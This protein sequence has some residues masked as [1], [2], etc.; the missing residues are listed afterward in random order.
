MS[1]ACFPDEL[2]C[3]R[4]SYNSNS[5]PLC[6]YYAGDTCLTGTREKTPVEGAPSDGSGG[7]SDPAK[8]LVS[9]QGGQSPFWG[10][11]LDAR[12][13]VKF[14]LS[15]TG[16][17]EHDN[18]TIIHDPIYYRKRQAAITRSVGQGLISRWAAQS[19]SAFVRVR[20]CPLLRCWPVFL[21]PSALSCPD[22]SSI[23]RP[24]SFTLGPTAA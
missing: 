19:L 7:T 10:E 22:H 5:P 13:A 21:T 24:S 15:E 1:V 18:G 14:L 17:Y 4:L 3:C 6:S 16:S 12:H 11:V 2:Y 23:L 20:A 8:R 9:T